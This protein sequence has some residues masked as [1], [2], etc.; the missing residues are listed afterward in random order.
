VKF[1]PGDRVIV[2]P[3]VDSISYSG[4]ILG[5]PFAVNPTGFWYKVMDTTFSEGSISKIN[6]GK[7]VLDKVWY[8]DNKIDSILILN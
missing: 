8:R 4:I 6:L 1:K 7:I 2:N 3:G 5:G